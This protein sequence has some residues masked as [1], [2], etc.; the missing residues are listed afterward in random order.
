MVKLSLTEYDDEV[1]V[2]IVDNDR[3]IR[4]R[5]E[6]FTLSGALEALP[7]LEEMQGE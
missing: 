1:I 7:N 2:E 5:Y 4:V 6:F 3:N